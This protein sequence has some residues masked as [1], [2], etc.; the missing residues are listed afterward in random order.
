[1]RRVQEISAQGRNPGPFLTRSGL[2]GAGAEADTPPWVDTAREALD[3]FVS[4]FSKPAQDFARKTWAQWSAQD[5]AAAA[6]ESFAVARAKIA[7]GLDRFPPRVDRSSETSELAASKAA[8][9]LTTLDSGVTYLLLAASKGALPEQTPEHWATVLAVNAEVRRLI[10]FIRESA[11]AENY[12]RG[13]LEG[14]ADLVMALERVYKDAAQ[15]VKDRANDAREYFGGAWDWV[16]AFL[17]QFA[18]AAGQLGTSLLWIAG[19]GLGMFALVSMA[20][21]A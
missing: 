16:R 14:N 5:A 19:L 21:R 9:L 1:M 20:R 12:T 18:K 2:S 7:W 4:R 10:P 15:W 6:A 3:A 17:E 13:Y 8:N 11:A